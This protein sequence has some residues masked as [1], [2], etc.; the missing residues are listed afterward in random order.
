MFVLP[1]SFEHT[2]RSPIVPATPANP[3]SGL[4]PAFHRGCTGK[5]HACGTI[6]AK[7]NR[8]TP[9]PRADKGQ[10]KNS[11]SS[12]TVSDSGSE[13]STLNYN[14]T[15]SLSP[16]I[17]YNATENGGGHKCYAS[18]YK[19]SEAI[20]T[21][22]IPPRRASKIP[23]S[24]LLHRSAS[25]RFGNRVRLH[26][27]GDKSAE[28]DQNSSNASNATTTHNNLTTFE[29][30]QKYRS[31]RTTKSSANVC[32]KTTPTTTTLGATTTTTTAPCPN[33]RPPWNSAAAGGKTPSQTA[34][35]INNRTTFRSSLRRRNDAIQWQT[36][37][38]RSLQMR[39]A[40]MSCG[41]YKNYDE[42]VKKKVRSVMQ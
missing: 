26:S 39:G 6:K 19:K 1:K 24:P 22:P 4:N 14:R 15:T 25:S 31:F 36:L 10:R 9:P 3:G 30:T 17:K 5:A 32:T 33:I 42:T 37:W 35:Q 2:L 34:L 40:S 16:L 12:E 23:A 27:E 21:S 28:C 29:R 8:P 18:D 38:E 11:I 20:I 13:N 7:L 41:L